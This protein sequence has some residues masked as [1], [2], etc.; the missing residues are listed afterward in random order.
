MDQ[1]FF[2]MGDR[3]RMT[4]NLDKYPLWIM[5]VVSIQY[6]TSLQDTKY[7]SCPLNFSISFKKVASVLYFISRPKLFSK[8]IWVDEDKY[9]KVNRQIQTEYFNL[10]WLFAY[11]CWN[12][13]VWNWM[14]SE[15]VKKQKRWKVLISDIILV[16]VFY[17]EF[18]QSFS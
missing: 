4:K 9:E 17:L 3:E 11:K 8:Q 12:C 13:I 15:N 2:K 14:K 1:R 6:I 10:L 16:R 5:S 7:L 18:L